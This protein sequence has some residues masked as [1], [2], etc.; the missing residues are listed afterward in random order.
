MTQPYLVVL[1]DA[2]VSTLRRL[3]Q[4]VTP[5]ETERQREDYRNLVANLPNGHVVTADGP[6]EE[7]TAKVEELVLAFMAQRTAARL[8]VRR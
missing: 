5:R 2:S 7:V 8:G 6:V 3:K 4:E 1:L